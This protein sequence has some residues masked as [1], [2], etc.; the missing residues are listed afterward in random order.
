[1]RKWCLRPLS[2]LWPLSIGSIL[3][4]A[5]LRPSRGTVPAQDKL[6]SLFEPHTHISV[7]RKMARP[8]EFCRKVWLEEGA[9]GL[10]SGDRILAKA[11]QDFPYLGDRLVAHQ[12]RFGARSRS[13][14][15]DRGI[16]SA[17]NEAV[18]W[19]AHV[20]RIFTPYAGKALPERIVRQRIAL[21][22]RGRRFRADIEG[23]ISVL[24]R[25]FGLDHCREPSEAGLG[26]SVDRDIV[27]ATLVTITHTLASSRGPL[28]LN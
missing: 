15:A 5:T 2:F 18:A 6:V 23:R 9:G 13:P 16:P 12:Q 14:A 4:P 7:R 21:F 19:Q 24:R 28:T 26:R 17:A 10:L 22:R 3:R 27:T 20:T 1:M 8:A 25:N 11:G